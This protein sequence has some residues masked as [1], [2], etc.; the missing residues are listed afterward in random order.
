MLTEKKNLIVLVKNKL[1]STDAIL[2]VLLEIKSRHPEI[3]PLFLVTGTQ[4]LDIIKKNVHLKEILD[5]L[6]AEIMCPRRDS[7]LAIAFW[8]IKFFLRLCFSKNVILK[9]GDTL[10]KHQVFMKLVSLFS[11]TKEIQCFINPNGQ[12]FLK[13]LASETV[14]M[15]ERAPEKYTYPLLFFTGNYDYYLST[16]NHGDFKF[17]G[18]KDTEIPDKKLLPIG[19]IRRLPEWVKFMDTAC[20]NYPL[21]QEKR[22]YFLFILSGTAPVRVDVLE[23]APLRELLEEALTVLKKFNGRIH[24]VFKPHAITDMTVFEDILKRT[25]YQDYTVDHGHPMILSSKARFVMSVFYSTTMMDAYY[26]GIPTLEYT[27]YD[28]EF[29]KMNNNWSFAGKYC[30][31]FIDRDKAMLDEKIESLLKNEIKVHRSQE[32]ID[33]EYPADNGQTLSFISSLLQ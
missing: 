15:H 33:R 32:E 25:G 20:R 16:L 22:P 17:F 18:C 19:Y 13:G 10:F 14:I 8:M 4:N 7:K 31:I 24:T 27:Y 30:D 1:L 2:P 5:K 11:N 9:F 23:E 6:G 3:R 21:I 29:L 28:R 26:L 12:D